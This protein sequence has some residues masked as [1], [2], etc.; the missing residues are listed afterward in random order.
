MK[1][2]LYT[3]IAQIAAER[4]IPRDA[5]LSSVQSALTTV[6]KRNTGKEEDATVELDAATGEMQVVVRK[7]VVEVVNDADLE[8]SLEDAKAYT[9]API[10]GEVIKIIST[11][12]NFGRIAA[13]TVKQVVH[14]KIRDFE[15]ETVYRE[16]HDKQGEVLSG[17]IQR[18]DS[19]D[20]CT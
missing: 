16:Y 12:E 19:G 14:G 15:R 18:A 5:V 20:A 1:S 17:I 2:D 4:G 10:L 8:I 6:Y 11:P 9:S 13:Q 7:T 3:A